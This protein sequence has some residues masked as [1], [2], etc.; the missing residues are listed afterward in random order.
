MIKYYDFIF[1][2]FYQF[3][4]HL[5]RKEKNKIR[6]K[7]SYNLNFE[8]NL[9]LPIIYKFTFYP[10]PIISRIL[11]IFERSTTEFL[12]KYL[13]KDDTVV[14]LGACYG[15][16]T[17]LISYLVGNNGRVFSYEPNIENYK[18]L[19]ANTKNLKNTKTF[20]KAVGNKNTN[21]YFSNGKSIKVE[22]ISDN[23]KF[24]KNVDLLFIDIDANNIDGT[25]MRQELDLAKSLI[26]S[27]LLPKKIFFELPLVIQKEVIN[28]FNE[29]YDYDFISKRHLFFRKRF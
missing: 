17:N 28:I 22:S 23:L 27:E 5:N 2:Y 20:N 11:G 24:L 1:C 19:K 8:I 7:N 4:Y 15:Y 12:I 29:K 13:K 18:Y 9:F 25:P 14:E 21:L 16:F 10:N 6:F 26:S 3:I